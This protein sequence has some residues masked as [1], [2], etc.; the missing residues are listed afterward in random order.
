MKCLVSMR[1]R[2]FIEVIAVVMAVILG[3]CAHAVWLRRKEIIQVWNN[4]D[5]KTLSSLSP[6][7]LRRTGRR[8]HYGV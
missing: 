8:A 2:L 5:Q 3:F 1:R 6:Y 4:R 7:S